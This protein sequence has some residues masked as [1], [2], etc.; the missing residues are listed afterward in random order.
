MKEGT[1]SVLCLMNNII[2]L[3]CFDSSYF[4]VMWV[5]ESEDLSVYIVHFWQ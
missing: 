4:I 2:V 3:E 1:Y 5:S